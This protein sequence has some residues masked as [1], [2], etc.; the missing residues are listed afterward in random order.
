MNYGLSKLQNLI[1]RGKDCPHLTSSILAIFLANI[2][3]VNSMHQPQDA[4]DI[5]SSTF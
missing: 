2:E 5:G 4:F 1:Q 3:H